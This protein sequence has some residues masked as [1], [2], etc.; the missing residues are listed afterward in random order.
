MPTSYNV[1]PM[2]RPVIDSDFD[3]I[4]AITNHYIVTTTAHFGYEALAVE[5]YRKLWSP[6]SRFPWFAVEEAGEVVGYAKSGT[7]RDRAAYDWTAEVGL[8]IRHDARGKGLGRALYTALL[9]E[10]AAR[11]FRSAIAG[12]TL[13]NEPSIKLHRAL[14][15]TSVGV[16]RDA[17]FKHDM[18]CDVEFFQKLLTSASS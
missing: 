18:W 16:V 6:A 17:G 13:P 1:P 3:A 2:I 15:F 10:L 8:Y 11:D 5:Y 7:W 4:A 12:I 9:A 14:G